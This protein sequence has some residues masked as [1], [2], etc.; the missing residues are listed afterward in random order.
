[1]VAVFAVPIFFICLRETLETSI[2][3]SILLSF[4][5]QTLGPDKDANTYK[6]L[7]R[8]VWVGTGLGLLI[9]IIIGAGM[10][11]AFYRL[12]KDFYAGTEDIWEGAFGILATLI[13]T[14]MGAALLRVSKLQDKWRYKL[15]KALEAKDSTK[16]STAG[17][18]FKKW[19]EKYAMFILPFVTVLR[20][21]LEAVVFIGGVGIG[22]PATSFP[23][24][25]FLGLGVGCLVGY[26]IYKGAGIGSIQTFL[27]ISTCCLYLVAAGLFSKAVWFFQNYKWTQ[28]I[29]GDLSETGSGPGSYDI[30]QSVWHVN[31]CGAEINGGGGWG[32]FNALLGWQNS[33]TYGSVISYN[34]YWIV[35]TIVFLS[36][37]YN[38]K[39]GHWPFLKAKPIKLVTGD[40]SVLDEGLEEKNKTVE[41]VTT[42]AISAEL[43]H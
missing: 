34:L 3:V 14:L 25:V 38:E 30:R 15:A 40:D 26:F 7:R 9:C 33:A 8:Q 31:C 12:G 10:I 4:L 1:M 21:G 37:R 18:R 16:K 35:V 42:R 29:G 19:C 39:T 11:G 5:K 36:M 24:P 28:T 43:E 27:I 2:V 23:L 20:E 41:A 22:F 32:I 6:K 13:I 17:S